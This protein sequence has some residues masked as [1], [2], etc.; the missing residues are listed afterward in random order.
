MFTLSSDKYQRKPASLFAFV[1]CKW[2]STSTKI[3]PNPYKSKGV[4][5]ISPKSLTTIKDLSENIFQTDGIKRYNKSVLIF[6]L[7]TYLSLINLVH[8]CRSQ[9][10]LREGNVFTRVC[11]SRVGGVP[12]SWDYTPLETQKSAVRILLE[13]FLVFLCDVIFEAL[14]RVFSIDGLR[15][16]LGTFGSTSLW[17]IGHA[18]RNNHFKKNQALFRFAVLGI[19]LSNSCLH[20][21]TNSHK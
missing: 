11:L 17:G 8:Y 1:Q 6:F 9:T 12:R 15:F 13:C 7:T 14:W 2:A 19:D 21:H 10:K 18:I 5:L 3:R 20:I 4:E 16:D